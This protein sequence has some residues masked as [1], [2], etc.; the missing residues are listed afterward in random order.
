MTVVTAAVQHATDEVAE[1]MA[2]SHAK[3]WGKGNREELLG[4]GTD[5][6]LDHRH[7]LLPATLQPNHNNISFIHSL[8][9]LY[10]SSFFQKMIKLQ[11]VQ[12]PNQ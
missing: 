2:A 10:S 12:T 3:D 5:A 11:Q 4:V 7:L 6:E 9:H 1:T 8:I